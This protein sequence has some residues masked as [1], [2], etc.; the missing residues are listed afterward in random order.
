MRHP[1]I[2]ATRFEPCWRCTPWRHHHAP[3]RFRT[4]LFPLTVHPSL[5]IRPSVTTPLNRHTVQE[6]WG[7]ELGQFFSD[8][9]TVENKA[10]IGSNSGSHSKAETGKNHPRAEA[11]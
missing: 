7:Q 9:V 10:I 2:A 4:K 5:A 6:G 3:A 1:R 11:R 8:K